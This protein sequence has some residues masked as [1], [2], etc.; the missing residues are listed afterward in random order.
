M[1]FNSFHFLAFFPIVVGLYWAIPHRFRWA[2]LLVT[3]CYFYAAFIPAYL[4]ILFVLI[5]I[6]Y[7]AGLAISNA[8]G[9]RRKMFLVVSLLANIGMLAF[10]K[11][12]NFFAI[13]LTALGTSTGL[14]ISAKTLSIVLPIGL[15]FHTFQ[16]MSYTIEVYRGAQKAERHL[17]IYAV[18]VLFW[19]QLVAG[20]IERPQN[21]LHQFWEPK[22][23]DSKKSKE[24][25]ELIILGFAKKV[26][27]A[28]TLAKTVNAVYGNPQG[29]SGLSL[30]IAAYFFSF[31]IY[32]D[33]SGYSDIARGA[34]KIM[35]IEL[36]VNFDRPYGSGTISEF[37]RRWHIS[38]STWFR[39]YVFIPLGGSRTSSGRTA[40][41]LM[42]VFLVSGFWHGANWTF[43]IWGGLHG[44][45][46][47]ASQL[48]F[49]HRRKERPVGAM[50][51]A[52]LLFTFNFVTLAWVFFR[53]ETVSKAFYVL[54][55]L[56]SANGASSWSA[57]PETPVAL[58]VA[59]LAIVAVE[60]LDSWLRHGQQL[61]ATKKARPAMLSTS[62]RYALAL[63]IMILVLFRLS[64]NRGPQ[65]FIYFQF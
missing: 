52:K 15:S 42:I 43:L 60:L 3:S 45:A 10:F 57:L 22:K 32:Y 11:Y 18:Y 56:G 20:P 16:S 44:M 39:D 4:L 13:N 1:L 53:A 62:F 64:D 35:G 36:M 2:W 12:Y 63:G 23:F 21:L 41:N 8:Q 14:P 40:M 33:F 25:F 58:T 24:G 50:R 55:H 5:I 28:D 46:L 26:L 34:A 51:I 30:L 19:P 37:W 9:G 38:L 31:Q 17:G 29:H 7:V 59:V 48:V 54:A 27:V 61:A 65:Q 6:D 49:G 47:V